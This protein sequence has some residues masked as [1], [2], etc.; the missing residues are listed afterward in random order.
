MDEN[1]LG[2]STEGR[3]LFR[4]MRGL[5]SGGADLIYT[6]KTTVIG[7]YRFSPLKILSVKQPVAF[8]LS[9]LTVRA[10]KKLYAPCLL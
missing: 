4:A 6:A 8:N 2:D 9:T 10:F 1:G 3:G 5:A 7:T